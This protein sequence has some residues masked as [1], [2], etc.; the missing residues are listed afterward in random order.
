MMPSLK[1]ATWQMWVIAFGIVGLVLFLLWLYLKWTDSPELDEDEMLRR[2]L[3][4]WREER[5]R[6]D[7]D[8]PEGGH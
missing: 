7:R 6:D 4:K 2:N 1:D 5:E 3:E 8:P